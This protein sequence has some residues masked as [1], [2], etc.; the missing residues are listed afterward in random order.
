MTLVEMLVVLTII[1]IL[2]LIVVPNYKS[3]NSQLALQRSA[4]KFSQDIRQAEEMAFS[5]KKYQDYAPPGYGIYLEENKT[6]YSLYVDAN[7]N[8]KYDDGEAVSQLNLEKG[9]YIKSVSS[10]NKKASINFRPPDPVV[11]LDISPTGQDSITIVLALE[12]DQTKTRN[13]I[14]NKIGL[15]YVQ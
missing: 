5:G 12:S 13:I 9:V 14:A 1:S 6:S 10:V 2:T 3:G 15:I 7:K 11:N 4:N 8:E